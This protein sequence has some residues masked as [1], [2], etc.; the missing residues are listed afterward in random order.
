LLAQ[1]R[2]RMGEPARLGEDFRALGYVEH[3]RLIGPFDNEGKLGLDAETPPEAK[4]MA[5]PD[6]LARFPGRE[7]PVSWRELP[8]IV[9]SGYVSFGALLRPTE[10]VCGL[11]E[12]FVHS[13]K[14]RPLSLWLGAGGA[15]KLYWNGELVLRDAAYRRPHPDRQVAMVGARAGFNRLLVKVCVTDTAWGFQLRI[16]D[17]KGEPAGGLRFETNTPDALNIVG[18]HG[19]KPPAA[20][21]TALDALERAAAAKKPRAQ[22]LA[23][24]ARY[25]HLS[26]S[27]DPAERRAPELAARAAE[28]EPTL[29]HLELA[30]SLAEQRAEQMRFAQRA[31]KLAPADPKA[32]F[33][34]ALV[35]LGGPQPERALPLLDAVPRQSENWPN[36]MRRRALLL[37]D[38]ELPELAR[39]G[40]RQLHR[41]L[42]KHMF[43]Q[44]DVEA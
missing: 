22:D 26:D 5:A 19:A 41:R 34:Q 27:D 40:R 23:R 2:M 31:S 4:R 12:T 35:E 16:G 38:L 29:A 33:L 6:L 3:W 1:A 24:L 15:T 25:L 43:G 32:K 7:R 39:A 10:N 9:K 18:G 14:A 37:R 17:A 28:L 8:P 42:A 30:T 20:P 21:P 13:D 44:R 11:A 36:A